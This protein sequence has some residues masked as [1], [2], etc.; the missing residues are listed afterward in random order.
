MIKK[1]KSGY[2]LYSR[3]RNPSTGKRRNLGTFSSRTAALKT[4]GPYNSLNEEVSW[5]GVEETSAK[6]KHRLVQ[7]LNSIR[8]SSILMLLAV[9]NCTAAAPIQPVEESSFGNLP[10]GTA[11]KLFTLRNANGMSAKVIT[12]GAILT[13]LNVPDRHAVTTNVVLG[14]ATLERYLKGFPAAAAIMGRV[15]NRIGNS[16][17][18]LDGVE[19]K[20]RANDGPNHLHGTFG[21]VVWQGKALPVTKHNAAVELTYFSAE[22]EEG[23]PGNLNVKVTYTLTDKNELRLD[24]E[25]TTDK[26]TPINLTSHAYLNLRGHSD[27]LDHQLELKAYRYTP[28]DEG[29]IPTGQIDSVKGTPLDFTRPTRIG[30][31]IE[32]LKPKPG[33]YD[34]NFVLDSNGGELVEAGALR[35]PESGRAMYVSTT[36]PGLQ[37]YS[38]NHLKHGGVCFETQHY[39]DSINHPEFPSVVLRPGKNFRSTT[40]FAFK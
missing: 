1:I 7:P 19:Y 17:F 3:K 20:L 14:A 32:Q 10:D 13:E 2:R 30:A 40:V 22:G 28:T 12:Y 6:G 26:A 34:H 36:E 31:R 5:F 18:T 8:F 39:P 35:D 33:G 23:F 4:S 37:L 25:A 21:K 29:L 9:L 27:V 38:G 24:Y 16:R 11:I 15:A